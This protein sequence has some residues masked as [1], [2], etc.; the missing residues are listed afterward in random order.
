MTA[1]AGRLALVTGA[2][3]GIGAAAAAALS[4]AGAR[5]VRVARAFPAGPDVRYLDLT[6]DLTDPV[7]VETLA[8]RVIGVEGVPAVVVSN[9]GGFLLQP[10]ERTT[11]A[12]FDGQVALNLRGPFLL[13]RAF[14]PVMRDVGTGSFI[15]V[16]SVAD[17]IGLPENAAYA[18]SK[19]GLRGLHETL[20]AEYRGTGVRLTLISPGATDTAIWDPIQP[21]GRPGFPSRAAMLRPAD[22]ADA[23]LFAATRPDHVHVDWIRLQP[24]GRAPPDFNHSDADA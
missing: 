24:S 5:V 15:S 10:L 13:A 23:I 9:A 21:E 19:Y 4:R 18:A 17:H 8:A 22:V 11:P 12:D 6:C 16:G 3:R 2:T 20:A 14:L 1:L 7:Q